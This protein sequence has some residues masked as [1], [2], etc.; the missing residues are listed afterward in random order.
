MHVRL[1]VTCALLGACGS[2]ESGLFG[3]ATSRGGATEDAGEAGRAPVVD[4][5]PEPASGGATGSGG[6]PGSGGAAPGLGGAMA[7]GGKAVGLGGSMPTGGAAGLATGGR[8]GSGGVQVA[9]AGG[10]VGSGGNGTGG[11]TCTSK[12]HCVYP[13]AADGCQ[14]DNICPAECAA[15]TTIERHT[16]ASGRDGETLSCSGSCVSNAAKDCCVPEGAGGT[17]SGCADDCASGSSGI[18][19]CDSSKTPLA[20]EVCPGGWLSCVSPFHTCETRANTIDN[21]GACGNKCPASWVC[22]PGATTWV[23]YTCKQSSSP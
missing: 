11:S 17:V 5:A 1:L 21:C 3:S 7:A 13:R 9:G 23:S 4:A 2:S 22:V 16:G 20:C 15:F 8:V 10:K 19:F 14:C 12:T 18:R 6:S